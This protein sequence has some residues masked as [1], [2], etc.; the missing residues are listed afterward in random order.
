VIE[1]LE[2]ARSEKKVEGSDLIFLRKDGEPLNR[3]TPY[4]YRPPL[5]IAF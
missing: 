2:K 4:H 1:V 5:K 3:Y